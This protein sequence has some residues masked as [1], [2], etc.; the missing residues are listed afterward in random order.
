MND[1]GSTVMTDR[2]CEAPLGD[3][4]DDQLAQCPFWSR[5][6][7]R[8]AR[9]RPPFRHRA[10]GVPV[11][12]SSSRWSSAALR[13]C[14]APGTDQSLERGHGS[15]HGPAARQLCRTMPGRYR[16][17][18]ACDTDQCGQDRQRL[19]DHDGVAVRVGVSAL[20]TPQIVGQRG[21]LL[22]EPCSRGKCVLGSVRG[23]GRG[24]CWRCSE[25]A[26]PC[27]LRAAPR[28]MTCWHRCRSVT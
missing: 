16:H 14:A 3:A 6:S 13:S 2:S 25:R 23:G 10:G 11:D 1:C 9:V 5:G 27:N 22:G 26:R 20:T 28:M 4:F 17:K 7:T 24:S 12:L 18:L 8:P 21:S 15:R 19:V